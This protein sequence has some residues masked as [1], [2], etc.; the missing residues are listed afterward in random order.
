MNESPRLFEHASAESHV[1]GGGDD[2]QGLCRQC[3]EPRSPSGWGSPGCTLCSGVEEFCMPFEE[4]LFSELLRTPSPPSLAVVVDDEL[5][6]SPRWF[7]E[8]LAEEG[9]PWTLM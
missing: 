9:V 5:E 4:H 8:G 2:P 3:L 7:E 1:A 6:N